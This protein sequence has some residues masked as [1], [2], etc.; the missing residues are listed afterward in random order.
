MKINITKAVFIASF[1]LSTLQIFAQKSPLSEAYIISTGANFST[2]M[3]QVDTLIVNGVDVPVVFYVSYGT[4]SN[5]VRIG[6]D[7]RQLRIYL[8]VNNIIIT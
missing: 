3:A 5:E 8:H 2:F 7:T 1:I 4:S 6:F